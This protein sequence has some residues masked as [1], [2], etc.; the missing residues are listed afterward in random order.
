MDAFRDL[1]GELAGRSEDERKGAVEFVLRLAQGKPVQDG[2]DEG[3]GLAGAGLG[4]GGDVI[5]AACT[6]VGR[7]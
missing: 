7:T 2:Q 1:D 4:D 6:G 5:A 3:G